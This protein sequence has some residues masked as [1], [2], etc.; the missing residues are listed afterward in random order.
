[1]VDKDRLIRRRSISANRLLDEAEAPREHETEQLDLCTNYAAREAQ[2]QADEA[3][4]ARERVGV[5][6]ACDG[7]RRFGVP[8]NQV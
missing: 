6:G 5:Y 3:A 7:D 1:M 4:H 8:G 2:E